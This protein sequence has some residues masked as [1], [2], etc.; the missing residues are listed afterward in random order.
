MDKEH[1]KLEHNS[2]TIHF[3]R[4]LTHPKTKSLSWKIGETR[5]MYVRFIHG[6]E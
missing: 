5:K 4:K 3:T 2:D 6:I 1:Q